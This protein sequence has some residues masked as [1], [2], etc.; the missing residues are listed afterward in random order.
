M[1]EKETS[2]GRGI[3]VTSTMTLAPS[4]GWGRARPA[5]A[6]AQGYARLLNHGRTLKMMMLAII[7]K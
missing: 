3:A 6:A 5:A 1:P 2:S 4:V 7:D